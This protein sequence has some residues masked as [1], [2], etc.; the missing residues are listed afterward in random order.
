MHQKKADRTTQCPVVAVGASAGGLEALKVLLNDLPSSL[1]AAIVILT[2]VPHDNPS[3]LAEVLASFCRLPVREVAAHTKVAPNVVYTAPFRR[4]LGISGGVLTL[5]EPVRD[6]PHHNI[7]RFLTA[8]AEDQGPNGVAV[9]LSGAGSDGMAGALRLAKAGGLVL[10]QSPADA[11]QPSMPQSVIQAGAASSVLPVS[12]LGPQLVRLFASGCSLED[13]HAS[14]IDKVLGILRERTGY[15]LSGYRKNTISRRLQKRMIM[16]GFE[17]PRE[18]L[19]E[20]EANPQEHVQLFKS[21]LIGVTEFFRDPESFEALRAQV[22]PGLFKG[23]TPD[24]CILVWVVG[25]STGEE[26]YSLAMFLNDYMEAEGVHCGIKIFASDIDLDAV[27][28]ARKGTYSLKGQKNLSASRIARY[29]KPEQKKHTVI[30]F[31]RERIVMVHHNLLQDPPFL[32]MDLVV[33]RNVLIYLSPELQDRAIAILHGA[34]NPGGFLFLGPAESV[35]P[36]AG[37]LEILDKRWKIFRSIGT[38]EQRSTFALLSA[39]NRT[40]QEGRMLPVMPAPEASP[41]TV[42]ADALKRRYAPAAVL[43]DRDFQVLHINRDTEPYLKIPCGEP[44]LNLLKLIDS[45]LRY[46]LRSALQEAVKTGKAVL[47]EGVP[48]PAPAGLPLT[49]VVDPIPD[50]NGQASTL[51]VA[52]EEGSAA[53]C[54]MPSA[55]LAGLTES[56]VIQRYETELQSAYDR[57]RD[58]LEKDESLN[59]ELRASN[60]ELLSMNEELQSAN[61]ELDASREEL[62]SLNE[63]LSLKVEELSRANSF[64]ENLLLSTNLA[65]VF[66]DGD[67]RIMHSTPAARDVFHVAVEDQGRDFTG[68]KSKVHDEHH[69]ADIHAVIQGQNLVER[70]ILSEDGRNFLKRVR[71]YRTGQTRLGGVVLTYSDVTMLKEAERVLVR[72]NEQLEALVIE[73]SQEVIRAREETERRAAELEAIMEQTPAAIWITRD[74]EAK[75]IVGNQASYQI[76]GMRSG[77]NVSKNA[78]DESPPYIPTRDGRKLAVSELPMQRAARGEIVSQDEIDLQFPEGHTLTILGNA[79]PL[80]DSQGNVTGAVGVF[81][82]VT[83]NKRAQAQ[84]LRWQRV[85]EKAEFGLAI[86]DLP[87]GTFSAVNPC[88]ARERGY[89]QEELVGQPLT[90]VFPEN[91]LAHLFEELKVINVIGHGLFETEH[92]R[93]DGSTFPVLLELTVL[94]DQAGRPVNR[95]AHVMDITDRKRAEQALQV[96]NERV[97]LALEAAKAG[98]WEWIPGTNENIWSDSVWELYGLDPRL[99]PASYDSWRRAISTEDIPAVE[100]AVQ[101]SL[102]SG[103]EINIE[104]RVNLPG[105]KERWLI[106]RGRPQHG[107]DGNV[108]RYLGIVMDITEV[109]QLQKRL[110]ESQAQLEAALDSMSDAVFISDEKGNFVNFNSGFAAFH[111]FANKDECAK[112][113]DEYPAFLDVY[114]DNGELAPVDRWA[115]PRAL[116]GEKVANAE[117]S[118]RRRDT[119]ESWVGSYS[120]GPIRNADGRIVGSVVVGRDITEAKQ[121][122]LALAK[123]NRELEAQ[124][125][126]LKNLIDNAPLV[127]GAVEGP[128]HTFILANPA[129]EAIPEDTS[130]SVVGRTVREVFPSVADQ[131]SRLFEQVYATGLPVRLREYM[132]PVGQRT[133]WWNAEYIP[134]F[135]EQGEV[136][137][138]LIIGHEVTELLAARDK[139]QKANQ[140][141]SEFLANMSHEIRTP[142]NGVLGM[143][144]LLETTALD[145]EQK[146]YLLA[147]IQSSSRLTQLLT[148]IL[149]LSRIE[150]GKL[151]VQERDFEVASLKDSVLGLFSPTAKNKGLSLECVVSGQVPPKLFGDDARIRQI[152]F[153]L[154]GN[155]VKFTEKGHVRV[156]I[157]GLSMLDPARARLLFSVMDTGI[158]SPDA[159]LKD[160]FEPFSQVEGA[161]TRRFQGAGLGLSIVRKLIKIMGGE[162]C[163]DS[164]VSGGTIVN[165]TLPFNLPPSAMKTDERAATAAYLPGKPLRILLAED[166]RVS[167]ITSK[168]MLEKLGHEIVAASD[169]REALQLLEEKDDFDLVLMDIQMPVM[170]GVEAA[171]SIRAQSRFGHKG[172]IPI[173]AMTAYAMTGDREK[174]LEAGMDDYI[175]KPVDK[176]AL[177]GVIKRVMTTQ[178]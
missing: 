46:H 163:I 142:L 8:L 99:H 168:R 102:A 29:F 122:A 159:V 18:Y 13:R 24:D 146:E 77:S 86:S 22:L 105:N 107:A 148:D 162:L 129:Y 110:M 49:L 126:F 68:I 150:A 63:E 127:I 140:A 62:Q 11:I 38:P 12:E 93:K 69:L 60:E 176:A 72:S 58:V 83:E 70:E 152:L 14:F 154:V 4:E 119:G 157:S 161:Y 54:H 175:A 9:I 171:K 87:H 153:N 17:T 173:V 120:F 85:F 36:H 111:R 144:Q 130:R 21:L 106:S 128:E 134:L 43:V 131:V 25:C 74:P 42:L 78:I 59:E 33:C 115:V 16:S 149:D 82:D 89:T 125:A 132:V 71:P 73:R 48:F 31:I 139:A 174:F 109:K 6:I 165:F 137:R 88:F 108:E 3:R 76:L 7:D 143:L 20:L 90:M 98:S 26:A 55:S 1:G 19:A 41:A 170:D 145:N 67:L 95:V 91:R 47:V 65:A 116:R 53:A 92:K 45:E 112:T 133:T 51:M 166:D 81:L 121:S 34:L 64:V 66:L 79:A 32:H 97:L 156:E 177:E 40:L 169:G 56:G 158:G 52:F 101:A 75:I 100:A 155:A 94:K 117:Y 57:L 167:M 23:K 104:W 5:L 30:P 164:S 160:I 118:L 39:R 138:I 135:G 114:L 61:E 50:D 123:S 44:S 113:F 103:T 172:R 37:K 96:A 2:H 124:S 84:A 15:D 35:S 147:A 136:S 27:E 151:M 178:S 10:V 28:T 141:K 80:K